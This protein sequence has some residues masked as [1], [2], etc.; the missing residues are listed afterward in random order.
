VLWCTRRENLTQKEI[1]YDE[2]LDRF[3]QQQSALNLLIDEWHKIA[4]R[5]EQK[6]AIVSQFNQL[7]PSSSKPDIEQARIWF[8]KGLN[9]EDQGKLDEALKAYE[10]AIE[11]DPKLSNPWNGKG[12]VFLDQKKYDEAL[13]AYE[14]AIELDPKSAHPW[15]GEGIV[16]RNLKKY[17]EALKAYEKAIK[18]DPSIAYFW[19]NKK[20]ALEAL[21]RR[22]EADAAFAIAK[23]LGYKG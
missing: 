20:I 19:N 4:S 10:K 1:E 17:D 11:L 23:E 2:L 7:M 5:P 15:N 21:G 6:P 22:S 18:L 12:N 3:S 8:E 16:F 13:K 14:K 9:L